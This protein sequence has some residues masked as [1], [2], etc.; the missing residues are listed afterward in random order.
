MLARQ[1]VTGIEACVTGAF[2]NR[3]LLSHQL[4]TYIFECPVQSII[5]H[6]LI[7]GPFS[8]KKPNCYDCSP[9][10]TLMVSEFTVCGWIKPEQRHT[11]NTCLQS[12]LKRKHWLHYWFVPCPTVR[13]QSQEK[14][15]K[16]T[17][18]YFKPRYWD[19]KAHKKHRVV[20]RCGFSQFHRPH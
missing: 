20:E 19:R 11:W 17:V 7:Q 4:Y 16:L 6:G 18:I 15:V 1:L 14:I 5:M 3:R 8:L 9:W 10:S 13:V 2:I 12:A